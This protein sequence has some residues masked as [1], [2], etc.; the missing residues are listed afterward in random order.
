VA[1]AVELVLERLDEL[2][3]LGQAIEAVRRSPTHH[4]QQSRLYVA[5]LG[6]LDRLYRHAQK[7][8]LK[9]EA[10]WRRAYEARVGMRKLLD[11]MDSDGFIAE[12]GPLPRRR[13]N[14]ARSVGN[15]LLELVTFS[16]RNRLCL[17]EYDRDLHARLS[18]A[19]LQAELLLTA[20]GD[21]DA[22]TV[23]RDL[24]QEHLQTCEALVREWRGLRELLAAHG[25]DEQEVERL[26]PA[27]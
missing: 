18:D 7:P 23:V 25:C 5:A 11:E 16:D 14:S 8:P 1:R 26:A 17:E 10:L 3:A 21:R 12:D 15:E 4:F 19:R 22:P 27:L 20:I 24:R 9:G 2:E 6:H 13:G